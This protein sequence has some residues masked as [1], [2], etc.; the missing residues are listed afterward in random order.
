[1]SRCM[2]L[3]LQAGYPGIALAHDVFNLLA[4]LCQGMQGIHEGYNDL[5]AGIIL[6]LRLG[7]LGT[8]VRQNALFFVHLSDI[9]G[10]WDP[11]NLTA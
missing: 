9:L 11:I 10:S 7:E 8:Y 6:G 2:L 3:T 5:D 1:M 4:V